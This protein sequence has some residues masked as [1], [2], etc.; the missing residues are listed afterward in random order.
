MPDD[1][2][3]SISSRTGVKHL[4]EISEQTMLEK[5]YIITEN[6][7]ATLLDKIAVDVCPKC[8]K[9]SKWSTKQLGAAI[10]VSWVISIFVFISFW[11][12]S[13]RK[14]LNHTSGSKP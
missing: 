10:M 13:Y 9:T 6:C 2:A 8:Q 7:L 12:F 5:K 4:T 3:K 14:E 11:E 1:V